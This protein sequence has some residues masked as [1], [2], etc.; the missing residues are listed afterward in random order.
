MSKIAAALTLSFLAIL[1]SCAIPGREFYRGK[2]RLTPKGERIQI[3][4][5]DQKKW[6]G[7]FLFSD[8]QNVYLLKEGVQGIPP[9]VASIPLETIARLKVKVI[10]NRSW[11]GYVLGFQTA[12]AI[13]LGLTYGVHEHDGAGGLIV[14]G[15]AAIPGVLSYLLFATS[16]P[17]QPELEGAI[18]AA[19]LIEFQKYARYPFA[20]EPEQKQKI[21]ESLAANPEKK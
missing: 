18:D 8:E 10:V 17:H 19:R 12:P 7:E 5:K 3:A 14:A 21:L 9:E 4:T 16:Q 6:E 20:L 1:N 13:V 15:L 11:K 2:V